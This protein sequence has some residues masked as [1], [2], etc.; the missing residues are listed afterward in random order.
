MLGAAAYVWT[1]LDDF[2]RGLVFVLLEVVHEEL[3]ELLD[4]LL[5]VGG[6]VPGL[7]RVE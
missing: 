5:E 3:A 4:L 6:A 7:G 1:G 2:G